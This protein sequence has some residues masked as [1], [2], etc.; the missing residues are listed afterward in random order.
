MPI[1]LHVVKGKEPGQVLVVPDEGAVIIGRS[2]N[3]DICLD[4][5]MLSR[6]HI[7]VESRQG[8]AI[9]TD[10]ASSN[11]TFVNGEKIK[12]TRLST[13]DKIKI[14]NHIF[15]VEVACGATGAE[16]SAQAARGG[17]AALGGGPAQPREVVFCALCYR[18][19]TTAEAVEKLGGSWLCPDCAD[20]R[21]FPE[22]MIDG[23]RIV[24][25]LGEGKLGPTFKAKHLALNKYVAIKIIRAE[26]ASD[27]NV[28]K[29]FVREA[30][31][32]GRLFHPNIVEMY[33][34]AV[35]NGH[36]YITSEW[37]EGDS[38]AGRIERE[39]R[40]SPPE[41][42]SIAAKIAEALAYAHAQR[43]LHRDVRPANVFLGKKGEV[44][45]GGFG[46]A[47][48]LGA[49]G[50]YGEITPP[51]EGKGT[52]HYIPPE[53]IEDARE[54]DHRADLYSLG[55]TMYHAL[56]GAPPFDAPSIGETIENVKA[57]RFVTLDKFQP[58]VPAEV[59]AVVHYAMNRDRAH[60]YASAQDFLNAIRAVPG[61][62][63]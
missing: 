14:G 51:R 22:N 20:G 13:G 54:V 27:E 41:V 61:F 37:I 31:I 38:L 6:Q 36:Y 17:L 45:L 50:E 59:A 39:G 33:D 4:D 49:P 32:G 34:A 35:S 24:E 9:V 18:A 3:A 8:A 53:Q 30:K 43:I 63:G 15:H 28:L 52:L 12:E 16:G 29:R 2:R 62:T 10:L 1:K 23:F 46:L 56:A 48:P 11:G 60:R 58:P 5:Q 55:A 47:R 25:K 19:T 44:K 57:G 7:R 21:P 42:L 40:V 26:R